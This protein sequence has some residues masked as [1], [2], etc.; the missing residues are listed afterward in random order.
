MEDL[1]KKIKDLN[2]KFVRKKV[3]G[4]I[5]KPFV[6]IGN[7]ISGTYKCMSNNFIELKRAIENKRAKK[8]ADKE[9]ER[10]FQVKAQEKYEEYLNLYNPEMIGKYTTKFYQSYDEVNEVPLQC[11]EIVCHREE[12][13]LCKII[14][15]WPPVKQRRAITYQGFVKDS[16]GKLVY[17]HSRA[18]GNPTTFAKWNHSPVDTVI[19]KNNGKFIEI[20]RTSPILDDFYFIMQNDCHSFM[21]ENEKVDLDNQREKE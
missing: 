10:E 7:A 2:R 19:R 12:G 1:E 6:A 9:Y 11:T 5:C 18:I 8:I 4:K 3:V 17:A 13:P 14:E 21:M 15:D 16:N 20:H